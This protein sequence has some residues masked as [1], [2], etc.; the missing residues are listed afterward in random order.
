L[1]DKKNN[2]HRG[3]KYLAWNRQIKFVTNNHSDP[4]KTFSETDI[5]KTIR[6]GTGLNATFN[7]I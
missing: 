5:I 4:N 2:G 6:E 7:N 1:F 3:Y